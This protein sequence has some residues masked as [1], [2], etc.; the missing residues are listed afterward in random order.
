[1]G[2][3]N[4]VEYILSQ[5]SKFVVKQ[6]GEWNHN[7]WEEFLGKIAEANIELHDELITKIG[8]LLEIS[9]Y[10]YFNLPE[11]IQKKSRKTKKSKEK[12][13]EE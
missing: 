1:M 9:K 6:K 4:T 13:E 8:Q 11:T 2:A 10:L 5:A 7:E 12:E 3:K